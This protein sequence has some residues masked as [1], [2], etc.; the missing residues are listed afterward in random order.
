MIVAG[1]FDQRGVAV[2]F[3]WFYRVPRASGNVSFGAEKRKLKSRNWVTTCATIDQN[4][5]DEI[6]S[7]TS[8]SLRQL[9]QILLIQAK[10]SRC[11]QMKAANGSKR[12]KEVKIESRKLQVTSYKFIIWKSVKKFL[13]Q[14]RTESWKLTSIPAFMLPR[15]SARSPFS[16]AA[17][18][19]LPWQISTCSV[20]NYDNQYC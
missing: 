7:V 5:S 13:S 15:I 17:K 9:M 4:V 14:R 20:N 16:A 3:S 19:R 12:T 11:K 8:A 1:R 6:Q 18:I 10:K 2:L